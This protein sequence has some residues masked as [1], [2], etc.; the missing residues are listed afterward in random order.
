MPA[1]DGARS[2]R[3]SGMGDD[4]RDETEQFHC[5]RVPLWTRGAQ[6]RTVHSDLFPTKPDRGGGR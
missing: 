3:P 5:S 4:R 1:P 2:N 6:G